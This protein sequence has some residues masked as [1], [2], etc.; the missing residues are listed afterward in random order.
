MRRLLVAVAGGSLFLLVAV[1]VP[2]RADDF[3]AAPKGFDAKR[4]TVERGKVETVEYDSRSAGTKR[5][6]TVYLPPGY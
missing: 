4:D 6:A 2:V 5:K 3:P 1:C